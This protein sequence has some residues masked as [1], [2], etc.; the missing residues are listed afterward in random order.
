MMVLLALAVRETAGPY[1]TVDLQNGFDGSRTF[2][3]LDDSLVWRGG[4]VSS[5]IEGLAAG[6][7][8]MMCRSTLVELRLRVPGAGIDSAFS[9][10]IPDGEYVGISLEERPGRGLSVVLVQSGVPFGYD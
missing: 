5:P 10:Q 3:F 2:L 9:I 6:G 8:E 1:L 4:P 7:I